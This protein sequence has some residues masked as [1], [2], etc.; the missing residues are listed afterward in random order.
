MGGVQRNGAN[1]RDDQWPQHEDDCRAFLKC[2][3]KGRW[4]FFANL[5]P[6]A[7]A[8]FFSSVE[9]HRSG[10]RNA[11]SSAVAPDVLLLSSV[12]SLS[13]AHREVRPWL[14]VC[15]ARPGLR[16]GVLA[17]TGVHGGAGDGRTGERVE[18][19]GRTTTER[20]ASSRSAASSRVQAPRIMTRSFLSS[21]VRR[22]REYVGPILSH[23]LSRW[24]I[25][26][27]AKLRPVD[28]SRVKHPVARGGTVAG[29]W[30]TAARW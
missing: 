19:R 27:D 1:G 30:T 15:L 24:S 13:P 17:A 29:A 8:G 2:P 21:S 11:L 28:T 9:P 14:K 23:L 16:G 6:S 22:I 3:R 18:H 26:L 10:F 7:A 25:V 4:D 12:P 20:P 5:F